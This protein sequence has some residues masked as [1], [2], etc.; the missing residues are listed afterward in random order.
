[1]DKLLMFHRLMSPNLR[2]FRSAT[3]IAQN[4]FI[5]NESDYGYAQSDLY[6]A[7]RTPAIRP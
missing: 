2:S 7:E 3:K 1:M 6:E 5:S 4:D